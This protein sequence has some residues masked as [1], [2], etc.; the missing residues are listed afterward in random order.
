MISLLGVR[1]EIHQKFVKWCKKQK[2]IDNKRG[3]TTWELYKVNS[4]GVE[5]MLLL[6]LGI[7]VKGTPSLE[8]LLMKKT[9]VYY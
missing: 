2:G 9:I 4:E 5:G 1:Y 3:A 8:K 7:L 6:I